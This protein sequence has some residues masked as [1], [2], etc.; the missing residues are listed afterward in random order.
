MKRIMEKI[1]NIKGNPENIRKKSEKIFGQDSGFVQQ[2]LF[3]YASQGK[4]GDK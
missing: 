1:Y 3:Y 4:L 2:Y